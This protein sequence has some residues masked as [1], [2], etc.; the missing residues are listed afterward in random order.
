MDDPIRDL[1]NFLQGIRKP[2]NLV[3]LLR[4]STVQTGPNNQA[5][6]TGIYRFR[7]IVVGTGVATAINVAKR[8]AASQALQYFRTH[9]IPE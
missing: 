9:G 6:H 4:F 1:N 3:P 8:V 2:E 7:N 5:T